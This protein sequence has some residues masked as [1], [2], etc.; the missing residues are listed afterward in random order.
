MG[1]FSGMDVGVELLGV[2]ADVLEHG[3]FTNPAVGDQLRFW[4]ILDLERWA[5]HAV[6]VYARA[7][8]EHSGHTVAQVCSAV[9]ERHGFQLEA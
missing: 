7:A 8:A 6:V 3:R 5:V 4:R 9:A 1:R 2:A